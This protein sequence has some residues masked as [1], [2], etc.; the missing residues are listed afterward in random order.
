MDIFDVVIMVHK[1]TGEVNMI[2]RV[3]GSKHKLASV[4]QGEKLCDLA[5]TL[6]LGALKPRNF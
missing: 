1:S 5:T 3:I 2:Q 6:S 4:K